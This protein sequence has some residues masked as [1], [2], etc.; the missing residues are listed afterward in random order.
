MREE[1]WLGIPVVDLSGITRVSTIAI[2]IMT[3]LLLLLILITL[4][5]IYNAVRIHK[6]NSV[7]SFRQIMA[8]TK[9]MFSWL[10]AG[11][12]F[13]VILFLGLSLLAFLLGLITKEMFGISSY[14]FYNSTWQ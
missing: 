9:E 8:N 5:R 2:S 11:L 14:W 6:S 13:V 12:L 1:L 7:L 10:W 4:V 3:D